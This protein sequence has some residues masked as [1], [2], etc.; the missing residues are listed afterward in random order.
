VGITFTARAIKNGMLAGVLPKTETQGVFLNKER[1]W[2][3]K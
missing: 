3:I 2:V 1:K